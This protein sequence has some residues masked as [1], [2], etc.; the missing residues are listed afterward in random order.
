MLKHGLIADREYWFR[1]TELDISKPEILATEIPRSI[2]IK[3]NIVMEDPREQGIRKI[4]NFG[5]TI[6]HAIETFSLEHNNKHSL[7]HGEAIAAG[8][9]CEAF[10]SNKLHKLTN[11]ELE[12]IT[13]YILAHFPAA[14]LG[15]MDHHRLIELMKHDKK[16]A[17]GQINFSLLSSI[18]QCDINKSARADDIIEALRYYTTRLKA[19]R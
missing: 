12:Q 8:M 1:L 5:H 15:Q 14:E 6:G 9:V 3:N 4:L 7:L 10:L 19:L 2:E 11:G 13:E 17:G 18:G 16:N